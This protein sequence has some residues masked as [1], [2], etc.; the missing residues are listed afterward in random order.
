MRLLFTKFSDPAKM[1][2]PEKLGIYISEFE[3]YEVSP[4]QG[5]YSDSLTEHP[6]FGSYLNHS[7]ETPWDDGYFEIA[8]PLIVEPKQT[9][10]FIDTLKPTLIVTE[11]DW[12]KRPASVT[13]NENIISIENGFLKLTLSSAN[14]IIKET[15][16]QNLVTAETVVLLKS[17]AF[18]I[19]V[20]DQD[21]SSGVFKPVKVSVQNNA[22][23]TIASIE[24]EL[25]Y[26]NVDC[27][28]H[29][30][31]RS[32][33]NFY[34]KWLTIRNTGS[35]AIVYDVMLSDLNL[36]NRVDLMA[37]HELTYPVSRLNKG[38][39]FPCLEIMYWDHI[40]D[41]L[42]YYPSKILN[43]DISFETEKTVVGVYKNTG[44]IVGNWDLGVKDWVIKYQNQI[45]PIRKE[46]PDFY[47]EGWAANLSINELSYFPELT[48]KRLEIA[49]K[50]GVRYM[51]T[52]EPLHTVLDL[53]KQKVQQWLDL[54]KQN[55][56]GTGFW[57]DW[58][59]ANDWDS[60]Q[61]KK[62][63][64]NKLTLDAEAYYKTIIES[65]SRMGLKAFHWGDFLQIFPINDSLQKYLSDKY[66]VYQQGQR[67]LKTWEEILTV[68]PDAMLGGDGGMTNPQW[69]SHLDGR[70]FGVITDYPY[71]Y[72]HHPALLPDIHLDRLYADMNRGYNYRLHYTYLRPYFRELNILS[73]FF[74]NDALA[75]IGTFFCIPDN[76]SKNVLELYG[77][78][79][80]ILAKGTIGQGASGEMIA[81]LE[82]DN[83]GYNAQQIRNAGDGQVIDP[84]PINTYL[85]EIEQ[86]SCAILEKRDP[87]NNA[88]T[89]LKS[90]IVLSACYQSA[91]T[92]KFVR[93]N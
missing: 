89:G 27:I 3:A 68:S 33:D 31:L 74:E 24:A 56:I 70:S 93:V 57:I 76:S 43:T 91:K 42:T 22:D 51:D 55:N 60:G 4:F 10:I 84:K 79:G 85:A 71:E 16:L 53:P 17:E 75:T 20:N 30:K 18:H 92:G 66:S 14:N 86:F 59:S 38:G 26:Q 12:A 2:F 46:W 45:S 13:K 69:V 78:K 61:L 65:T 50:I 25:F 21:Y 8:G 19:K 90:Q 36:P 34:H 9:K 32:Q 77:S 52:Y 63:N 64:I 35:N 41:A 40:G 28:L 88:L 23:K 87:E 11:T 44:E 39:F 54:C 73:L 58:G 1:H 37:G 82:E 49:G 47:C 81:F 29:Y 6:A 48:K 15:K 83:S 67:V 7:N 72:D 62:P 5:Y 80:S